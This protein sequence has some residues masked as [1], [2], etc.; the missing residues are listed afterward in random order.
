MKSF[1]SVWKYALFNIRKMRERLFVGD[2][3]K[4]LQ[5]GVMSSFLRPQLHSESSLA[6]HHTP[7]LS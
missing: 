1:A 4:F 6:V 3:L 5:R 7:E 2:G